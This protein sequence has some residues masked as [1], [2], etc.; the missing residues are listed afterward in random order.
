M[1]LNQEEI[2]ILFFQKISLRF[3]PLSH[4]TIESTAEESGKVK[5]RE[6]REVERE[7]EKGGKIQ[8][9]R[10]ERERERERGK[11]WNGQNFSEKK[12]K[13]VNCDE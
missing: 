1:I 5:E 9:E 4:S 11:E 2:Q 7:R 3:D 12:M 8:N 6:K 13:R 10:D